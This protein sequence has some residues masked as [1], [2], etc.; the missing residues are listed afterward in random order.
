MNTISKVIV[1]LFVFAAPVA[2]YADHVDGHTPV[3]NTAEKQEHGMMQGNMMGMMDMMS[4]MQPMMEACTEMMAT[5][6]HDK[7]IKHSDTTEG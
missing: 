7:N 3:S 2:A 5:M 4:K 6:P 1:T